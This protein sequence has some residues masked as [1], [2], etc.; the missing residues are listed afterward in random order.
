MGTHEA[1]GAT[2]V[3]IREI[4][5]G[6]EKDYDEWN[7]RFLELKKRAPGYLSTTIIAPGGR[8]SSIRYIIT[9]FKDKDS[10]ESWQKLE[11]RERMFEEVNSYSTPHY[12]SATGLETWFSLPKL[13]AIK[14]PPRWKMALVTFVAAF[15]ISAVAQ[16]FLNP[17]FGSLPAIV[18]SFV[19]TAIIVLGLTYFALPQLT[20]LL[21][22]WLYPPD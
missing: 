6:R 13:E 22:R 19:N 7:R 10:L 12:K 5:A 1:S 18:N 14:P 21:R 17:I 15:I 16:F 4:R 3:I 11:N 2:E 20:K 8:N 9:R